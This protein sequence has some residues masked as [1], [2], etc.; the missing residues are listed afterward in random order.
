MSSY[1]KNCVRAFLCVEVV[2]TIDKSWNEN[3][4][5]PWW[6]FGL[7]N[8]LFSSKQPSSTNW[9]DCSTRI[10]YR[11]SSASLDDVDCTTQNNCWKS[12]LPETKKALENK[13]ALV[14]IVVSRDSFYPK[15]KCFLSTLKL[16]RHMLSFAVMEPVEGKP[17][18][19]ECIL[20]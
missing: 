9:S 17:S 19:A 15:F 14:W 2:V 7:L 4:W 18:N 5:P 16:W 3:G 6:I 1:R 8:Y 11:I 10:I 20:R 12:I 13:L